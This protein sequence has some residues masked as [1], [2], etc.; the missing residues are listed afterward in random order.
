MYDEDEVKD[1]NI[2]PDLDEELDP[3]EAADL[4]DEDLDLPLG[5]HEDEEAL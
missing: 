1:M 2:G 3:L 5:F 4:L